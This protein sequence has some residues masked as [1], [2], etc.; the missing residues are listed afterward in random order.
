MNGLQLANAPAALQYVIKG[1]VL[2]LAVYLDVSLK[3]RR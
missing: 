1:I 3:K 2:V